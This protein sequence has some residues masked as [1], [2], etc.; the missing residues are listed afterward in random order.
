MGANI[1]I[2]IESFNNCSGMGA[3]VDMVEKALL[4]GS[5]DDPLMND[6]QD[7][8]SLAMSS[9]LPGIDLSDISD[10]SDI[11][12]P[13]MTEEQSN[14]ARTCINTLL[15]DNP[16]GN[17]VRLQYQNIDTTLQCFHGLS[18]ELPKCVLSEPG[19]DGDEGIDLPLSLEKKM[20]CVLSEEILYKPLLESMCTEL[21]AGLD[22]CLPPLDQQ[23]NTRQYEKV[24]ECANEHSI[25]LGEIPG[26]GVDAT[27]I[28]GKSIYP[29]FCTRVAPSLDFSSLDDRIAH[30]N[31][32]VEH[33]TPDISDEFS[34][35]IADKR[36]VL[37]NS[38]QVGSNSPEIAAA[39]GSGHESSESAQSASGISPTA[40]G[41]LVLGGLL[42]IAAIFS[43]KRAA[44]VSYAQPHDLRQVEM[45]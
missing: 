35:H 32:W 44:N 14:A 22:A 33:E 24:Q 28:T 17:F 23:Q 6:C 41:V 13:M 30:Y 37:P 9:E 38:Q 43:R 18:Q 34:G 26:I 21:H 11:D 15:G 2:A 4:A 16:V 31:G 10:L 39:F 12:D 27:L 3:I 19:S 1:S 40:I 36:A 8:M 7:L 20:A 45:A 5:L 29:S 42:L 25:F